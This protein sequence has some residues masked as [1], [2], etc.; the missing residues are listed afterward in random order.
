MPGET[1]SDMITD[2]QVDSAS[3]RLFTMLGIA[4]A[5]FLAFAGIV[6]FIGLRAKARKARNP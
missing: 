5:C 4:A 6:V 3:S 1:P 2:E